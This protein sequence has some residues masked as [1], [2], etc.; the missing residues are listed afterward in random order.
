MTAQ[1]GRTFPASKVV[2]PK[3]PGK[4]SLLAVGLRRRGLLTLWNQ[5]YLYETSY[6]WRL[7]GN[8]TSFAWAPVAGSEAGE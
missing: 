5:N 8:A 6:G 3:T 1:S 2:A 7:A 4:F